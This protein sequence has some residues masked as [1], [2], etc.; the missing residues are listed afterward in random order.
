MLS[1]R[2]LDVS[3]ILVGLFIAG[4]YENDS[5]LSKKSDVGY[6]HHIF[7]GQD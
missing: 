3:I 6:V 4:Q 2:V 1:I 5:R 7:L